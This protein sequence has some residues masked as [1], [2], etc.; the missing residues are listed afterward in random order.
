MINIV[1]PKTAAA[2]PVLAHG[3]P[4]VS[5]AAILSHLLAWHLSGIQR[6]A[7]DSCTSWSLKN[8]VKHVIRRSTNTDGDC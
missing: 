8:L 1:L 7:K 4:P 6:L 3:P 2:W 5:H